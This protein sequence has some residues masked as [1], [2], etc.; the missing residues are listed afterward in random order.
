MLNVGLKTNAFYYGMI[1][2][3][4][5]NFPRGQAVYD[6]TSV[7][8]S[9]TPGQFFGLGSGWDTDGSYAD[10]YAA[11]E[12]GHSL[13]RA[14]PNAGS[15]NPATG[16]TS[17]NCGHSRSDPGYPYGNTSTASAPIGPADGSME[18]FDV[19]DPYFGIARAVLPSSIWNDVMSY[20]N[21]QWL[22]DYTY[23]NMYNNMIAN[24]SLQALST[25]QAGDFLAASGVIN[26][27]DE[28]A[29]FTYIRRVDNVVNVPVL[30]PG[31]YSLRLL[32]GDNNPLA[33]HAFTPE[34]GAETG[35]LGFGMVV[36]FEPGT[37][38]VQI[39]RNADNMVLG[40]QAVSANPPV[41]SNVA[42]QGAPDP[43]TGVV[44][45][46]WT[47]SDPDGGDTLSFDVAYSRDNGATF[48]PVALALSGSS[49]RDRYRQP[50]W[51]RHRHACGS[52]PPMASTAPTPTAIPSSWR[53]KPPQPYILTPGDGPAHPLRAAGQ[54][55]R[56]RAGRARRHR[57]GCRADLVG[58]KP[59]CLG[60]RPAAF[61]WTT[62][63]WARTRSPSR[64]PTAWERPPTLRS[65]SLWTT[66]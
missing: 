66:T 23:T 32:D 63:R 7:G 60:Q 46:G 35:M 4:S 20:C 18:G 16:N 27:E 55:Q 6:K 10:W 25:P 58:R 21:S 61:R 64:Q 47:A 13:G 37:R 30:V 19:G 42:L 54:L 57:G 45:L 56:S 51:Q 53:H 8:P 1:S 9:G 41:I 49:T 28:V 33:E 3:A 29:G 65:P 44:T 22:S 39:V 40:S 38:M 2:D 48:Q 24:P 12:I 15:D 50:G 5:N 62:C 17:E 52:P 34:L 11:H 31:D 26:P 36:N 14:H 59:E 43:V